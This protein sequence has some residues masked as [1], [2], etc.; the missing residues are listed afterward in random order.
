[1]I[2]TFLRQL[3]GRTFEA[4]AKT[5]ITGNAVVIEGESEWHSPR[6]SLYGCHARD[7]GAP[8]AKAEGWSAFEHP[9]P[10]FFSRAVKAAGRGL[11]VDVG[12]N[13]GFYTLLA[14]AVSDKVRVTAYEPMTAV[15]RILWA[16]LQ[17]NGVAGRVTVHPF[18]AS[19]RDGLRTLHIPNG[20]HGL[21]ET[22]ASLS[23]S[24]K[25]D[26][27]ATEDVTARRLDTMHRR[28][29]RVAVIKVDAES[30]DLQVLRGA[31]G[32]MR[33][34]RPVVFLEVL[35]GADEAGLTDLLRR[36]RY[37][38][39]VLSL[40]GA[41]LPQHSVTHDTHAWNHMWLPEEQAEPLH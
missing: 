3:L 34:D 12:A 37:R 29:R 15:R 8:V 22:S 19:D 24:F 20:Q 31:E 30:H 2:Q 32:T 6:F 1:M 14:L 25:S 27:T 38:D 9:T 7:Q 4:P 18:A 40:R 41:A 23:A 13:T 33:R 17:V 16:N 28:D 39:V 36:C 21:V 35:L 11:V 5:S 26:V 10:H